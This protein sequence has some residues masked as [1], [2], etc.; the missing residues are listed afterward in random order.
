ML[1]HWGIFLNKV[2]QNHFVKISV[3][4]NVPLNFF[5]IFDLFAQRSLGSAGILGRFHRE[6]SLTYVQISIRISSVHTR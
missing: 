5:T 4:N 6:I 1:W 3:R 2:R